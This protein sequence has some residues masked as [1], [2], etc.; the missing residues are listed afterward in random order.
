MVLSNEIIT[1]FAKLTAVKDTGKK[2]TTVYGTAVKYNGGIYVKIDGSDLLT[3]I[4]TVTSVE[5]GER[6]LVTIKDHNAIVTGNLSNPSASTSTVTNVVQDV[7][8]LKDVVAD[9]VSVSEL[10][11]I[12]ATIENLKVNKA[13]VNDLKATNAEITTLKA[14]K[15][16]IKDLTAINATITNLTA[17]K[18]DIV[19]LNATNATIDT[20]KATV[21]EI[22]T[23]VSGNISSDNIQ[24]G[25]I[26]GDNLNMQTIFVNDAN[27]MNVNANK[28]NAGTINT[29]LIDIQSTSG[30]LYMKDNTI[31]IK[32]STRVRVQIGKD[33]TDDYSMSVWDNAGNLMFDARGLTAD[34]I[35]KE[36]I[37]NDM[38]SANANISGDKLDINSV[39]TEVNTNG[40]VTLKSSKVKL[41]SL[42]QTL[43]V[44]FSALKTQSDATKTKTD[45]NTT[46]IG[47]E[48]GRINT[49]IQNTTIV[50]DGTTVQLKDEYSKLDQT[51]KGLSSTVGTHTTELSGLTTKVSTNTSSIKQLNDSI[52]LKVEATD[53]DK[54]VEGIVIGGRNL[55]LTD[56]LK[57]TNSTINTSRF[58]S[59]G[60]VTFDCAAAYDGIFVTFDVIEPNTEYTLSYTLT[61]NSGVLTNI[62]GHCYPT[63][64]N[65]KFYINDVDTGTN[66]SVAKIIADSTESYKI[67][68]V[69]T[70]P[71]T[72]PADINAE[73]IYIQPN[74]GLTTSVSVTVGN[75]KMEKGNKV[76][77]WSPAP[78]DVNNS[79]NKVTSKVSE[80]SA[81]LSGITSRVSTVEKDVSTVSGDIKSLS[82][83][84]SSAE[85]KITDKA[86][87][88]T[89][90]SSITS[91]IDKV[92]IGGRNLLDGTN[93]DLQAY[94]TG[95]Y[96]QK[97][98][99]QIP[100]SELGLKPGD[101]VTFRVYLKPTANKGARARIT[102]FYGADETSTTYKLAQGNIIELGEEGYS[103]VTTTLSDDAIDKGLHVDIQSADSS[104]T[105]SAIGE[106]K[107]AKLEKGVKATDWT[108]S[109]DDIDKNIRDT[110][111]ALNSNIDSAVDDVS[112]A[113]SGAMAE[114]YTP[115]S[116][117]L[118]FSEKVESQLKQTSNDITASFT[119]VNSY[120]KEVEGKVQAFQDTVSNYIRFDNAGMEMGVEGSAFIS[121][122][123]NTKLAFCQNGTEVAYISNNKMVITTA[124]IDDELRIGDSTNGFFVWTQGRNGNLTLKWSDK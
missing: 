39:I 18:A 94:S 51:V 112:K 3:P 27:I 116:E 52:K 73:R 79:I 16:D 1:Q 2:D 69:F 119:T 46:Q 17:I 74:R 75:F 63:W 20:L 107:K 14:N 97:I 86:I 117:F 40:S 114:N 66:Y 47:I 48:Q 118:S 55:I 53:I 106:Y 62:G 71:A 80:I 60:T 49:L 92:E 12:N 70:T 88:N 91:A 15:A 54:A 41:D 11:A 115:N 109:P 68:V 85:S 59:S 7:S 13:E 89:V 81:D 96:Y 25:G 98:S 105:I 101:N 44:A 76:T 29:N 9:K 58:V 8:S 56:K 84:M 45:S 99:D 24:T 32:D 64:T 28:I 100:L 108:P 93:E 57:D 123:D 82:T 120:T 110:E 26:T 104:N 113:V 33:A 38:I 124:D 22:D 34:A 37:R 43:D 19:D 23:L 121:R 42:G 65:N 95:Q 30:N 50:K 77:D 78:E 61:K 72:I 21:A 111:E 4:N 102:Y 5:E 83:R 36:I 31:Q 103:T 67:K 87:I 90:S 6:V 35:K 122:L 10:E